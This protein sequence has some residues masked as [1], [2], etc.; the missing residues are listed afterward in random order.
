M[1]S[2]EL[3]R[4][5]GPV[6]ARIHNRQYLLDNSMPATLAQ[7]PLLI[8]GQRIEASDEQLGLNTAMFSRLLAMPLDGVLGADVSGEF[9]I[10]LRPQEGRVIFDKYSG[11]LPIRVQV[12]SIGGV[13][14]FHQTVNGKLLKAALSLGSSLSYLAPHMLEDFEAIGVERD[15]FSGGAIETVE[16][17][18]V[19]VSFDNGIV[20]MRFGAA[21]AVLAQAM[22]LANIQA[23][24]GSEVLDHYDMDMVIADGEI[25]LDPQQP[26][27][28]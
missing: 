15:I 5:S 17:Y 28:H 21:P 12:E 26:S 20:D 22:E 7:R 13:P 6:V 4:T 3:L 11:D 18:R 27:I 8:D 14:L 19:P 25:L 10:K 1:E 9:A 2:F 16:V 24:I 23:V